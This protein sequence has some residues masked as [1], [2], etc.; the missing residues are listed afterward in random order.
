MQTPFPN[1][2]LLD[3]VFIQALLNRRDQYHR[4][5][6]EI[7]PRLRYSS[8]VWVSEAVLI[9]VGNA[10]SALN[11]QGAARFIRQC[12]LTANLHVSPISRPQLRRAL[13][14][15]SDHQDKKW[16]LTDCLSFALM[17]DE[18]LT[19]ALTAD[20]HFLQ[21]GYVAMMRSI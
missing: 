2:L 19:H 4:I 13:E 6:R 5:A 3:T 7:F 10:L 1:R 11:R 12:Y 8:E 17:E 9:E 18:G 14:I 20:E 16:G 15:Y 21:A